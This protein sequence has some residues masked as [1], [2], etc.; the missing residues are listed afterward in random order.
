MIPLGIQISASILTGNNIG[1]NKITV[2]KIYAQMFIKTAAFWAMGTTI[3]LV[4]LR[5]TFTSIFT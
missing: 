1:A 4:L 2:A 3:L 5:E